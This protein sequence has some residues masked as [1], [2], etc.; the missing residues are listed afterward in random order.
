LPCKLK[1]LVQWNLQILL[2]IVAERA[3]RRNVQHLCLISQ[4]S[5]NCFLYQLFNA[6]K[7]GCQRFAGTCRSR[8]QG[9]TTSHDGWP[10]KLLRLCCRAESA[11]EP[12]T[13]DRVCPTEHWILSAFKHRDFS[14]GFFFDVS[15]LRLRIVVIA[16]YKTHEARDS[17]SE[18]LR[19]G[20]IENKMK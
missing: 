5:V 8:N 14:I 1:D 16:P 11:L 20:F 3:Q 13:D 17:V 15:L 10:S 7:K 2:D 19:L 12:F 6:G 4:C 18:S 9:R